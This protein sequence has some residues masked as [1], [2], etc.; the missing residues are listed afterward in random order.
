MALFV[1]KENYSVKVKSIDDQHKKLMDMINEFYDNITLKSN[2]ENV[3]TLL[4]NLKKYVEFHFSLEEKYM[5]LA[6]YQ[7]YN[8]HK[9]EH[10]KFIAKIADLEER[11]NSG[12]LVLSLEVTTF[13]KDWLINHILV[14]DQKYS[15]AFVKKKFV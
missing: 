6:E 15:E 12:R 13:L 9:K 3:T 2:L 4:S 5:V 1:W 14:S 7:G 11:I 10:E 8:Q